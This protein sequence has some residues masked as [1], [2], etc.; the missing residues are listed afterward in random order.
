MNRH[1]A[2]N[3]AMNAGLAAIFVFLNDRALRAQ[4]E[5]T[6]VALALAYGLV[7]ILCN[8][9]FVAWCCRRVE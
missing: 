5:E 1:V 4:L 8:A 6:F 9:V 3:A 7:T 2:Q